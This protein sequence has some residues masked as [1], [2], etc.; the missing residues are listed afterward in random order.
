MTPRRLVLAAAGAL[1]T[2]G[3]A[4]EQAMRS[5]RADVDLCYS[6]GAQRRPGLKG[7]VVVEIE[8]GQGGLTESA[9]ITSSTLGD[10]EVEACITELASRWDFPG[11][12]TPGRFCIRFLLDGEP[13]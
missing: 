2:P 10:P 3:C 11:H 5:H 6:M 12:D 7:Q 4:T 8:I 1:A 13:G 9:R